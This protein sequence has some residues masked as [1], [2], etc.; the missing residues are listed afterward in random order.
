LGLLGAAVA[1][2][3]VAELALLGVLIWQLGVA[4]TLGLLV[5]KSVG[6]YLLVR[7]VGRRGWRQF[8]AAAETGRPPGREVSGAA[9][10]LVGAM[11]VLLG[12]FIG[13]LLGVLA[14]LPPVRSALAGLAER[15][16][17][18]QVAPAVAGGVFGPRRVRVRRDPAAAAGPTVAA[19]APAAAT[20]GTTNPVRP[21]DTGA[22]PPVIEG[23]IVP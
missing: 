10:G 13:A 1:I 2:G 20:G 22:R 4:W 17:E 3:A 6:G 21:A 18:G 12:G 5:V 9:V 19:D 8:R 7:Q 11:L 15:L 23:E 16:V 14:Q